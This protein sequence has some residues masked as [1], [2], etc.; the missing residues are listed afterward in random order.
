MNW[1]KMRWLGIT[2]ALLALAACVG[3]QAAVAPSPDKVVVKTIGAQAAILPPKATPAVHVTL[4]EWHV[5]AS[6]A[7]VPA[8]PVTVEVANKG[9]I[10]HQVVVLKTDLA[11]EALVKATGGYK[12]DEETSGKD[13]GVVQVQ[14]GITQ[15][16]IFKLVPG[17]YVLICNIPAHY[18]Q[19]M[20]AALEVK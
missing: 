9:A 14:P 6:V 13:F 10:P 16:G 11:P 3:A 17:K 18:Q 15:S 4:S 8:G 7:L 1:T 12:I 19:G 5:K 20:Y 2:V